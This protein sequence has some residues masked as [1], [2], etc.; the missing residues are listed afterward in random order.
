MWNSLPNDVVEADTVNN[1]KNH[2]DKYWSNEDI[3]FNLNANVIGTGSLPI[4]TVCES[5]VKMWA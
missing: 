4:C 2:F 1:V 3:L 5:D